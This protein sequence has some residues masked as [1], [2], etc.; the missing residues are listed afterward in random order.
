MATK[1]PEATTALIRNYGTPDQRAARTFPTALLPMLGAR[2]IAATREQF[3][4]EPLT[5]VHTDPVKGTSTV[6]AIVH[7]VTA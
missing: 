7:E 2:A 6:E 3:G 1:Q 5:W 4:D